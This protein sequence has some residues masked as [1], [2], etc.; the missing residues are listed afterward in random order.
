MFNFLFKKNNLEVMISFTDPDEMVFYPK[1]LPIPQIGHIVYYEHNY[2]K[3][4]EVKH[5]TSDNKSVINV[6]CGPV[7][8]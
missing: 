2:G 1:H 7:F 4:E 6:I 5:I 3:V 8:K